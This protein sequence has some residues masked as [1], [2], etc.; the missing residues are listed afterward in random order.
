MQSRLSLFEQLHAIMRHFRKPLKET[1]LL[2]GWPLLGPLVTLYADGWTGLV[3][4][5][6]N[7]I[8]IGMYAVFIFWMTPIVSSPRL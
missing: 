5:L 6:P 3:L 2:L 7:I 8:Q 1:P 4:G